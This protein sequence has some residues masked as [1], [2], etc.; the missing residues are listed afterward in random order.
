M[1]GE[2]DPDEHLFGSGDCQSGAEGSD[3]HWKQVHRRHVQVGVV[4]ERVGG[5]GWLKGLMG[6]AG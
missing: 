2:C 3:E 1:G 6:V 5:C 4:F